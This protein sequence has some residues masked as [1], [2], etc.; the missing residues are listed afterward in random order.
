MKSAGWPAMFVAELEETGEAELKTG[1][2]GTQLHASDYTEYG[3]PVLNVRNIGFGRVQ[4]D[5]LETISAETRDRLSGHLL[6]ADDIVFGRKGAVERHL[7]VSTAEAGWLQGSDCLRLRFKKDRVI[8]RFVSYFLLTEYHKQ[9]MAN[10]CSHGATMAS[11]NQDIIRRISLPFP[12]ADVQ[13]KIAAI[14]SAYD[15]LIENNERRI[16]ILEE[17]AQNL[18]REWFVKFR[19]PGHK[20]VKM[21]GS[22]L[23]KI[24]QGWKVK[25]LAELAGINARSIK[26]GKEPDELLYIDIASVNPGSVN[27]KQRYDFS[28]APGRARRIVQHGDLIWSCVRPNR[29]SYALI[30]NPEPNLIVSTGFAVISATQTP[31]TYLYFALTTDDFVGYLTNHATGAAY[32]AV[33]AKD[34]ESATILKPAS[35]VLSRFHETVSPI[36]ELRHSVNNR[37]ASLRQTRD[38]LLPKLISSEVDVSELDIRIPENAA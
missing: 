2:F 13:K 3:T 32:P 5:K 31:F 30:L 22:P 17:M 7:F 8:P 9:W 33:T 34:F 25:S 26:K 35:A 29:K 6:I 11:L 27:L 38:L 14:L 28:A 37:N 4:P 24:P 36:L 12:S 19:F 20:K 10:H 16:K 18:Y 23:G 15:D 21:V 1:P